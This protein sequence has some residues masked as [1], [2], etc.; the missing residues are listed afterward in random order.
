MKQI[1]VLIA[2]LFSFIF[3]NEVYAQGCVAIRGSSS[4][5]IHH[6]DSITKGW[7]FSTNTLTKTAYNEK[8]VL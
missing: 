8:V 2:I 6:S 7:L 5:T 1:L 4:C 3:T